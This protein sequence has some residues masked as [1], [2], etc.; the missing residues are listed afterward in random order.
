MSAE[1]EREHY[2]YAHYADEAVAERFDALRFGGP[3]GR[4]LA[5]TQQQ[6]L[7]RALAP[8]AGRRVLDV[9]TGT[10]RAA[11]GLASLGASVVGVD[12]SFEMLAVARARAPREGGEATFGRADAHALPFADGSFDATVC[13]RVLM[14]AVDWP[15]ALAEVCRVSRWRVVIDFPSSRSFAA[16]ESA[17]RSAR[18]RRGAT[19]EAYRVIAISAVTE[20]LR[21]R[22]FRVAATERQFVLPI[23]LHKRVGR[24]GVTK[25]TERVLAV[26]GLLRV[27]GSP[28]T[29][30]AER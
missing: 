30:V 2:S 15:K 10:G 21:A 17:V 26:G 8:I 11:L 16:L 14:H 3:I 29:L 28:V 18:K 7:E 24:L 22:G 1:P 23:A 19:V 25:A 5:E 20:A 12:A 9:G 27:L 4:H 13:L 6:I